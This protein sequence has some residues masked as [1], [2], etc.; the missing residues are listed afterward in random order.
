MDSSLNNAI[1]IEDLKS[2][3]DE[4]LDL[5]SK[6]LNSLESVLGR[7]SLTS[8]KDQKMEGLITRFLRNINMKV[9]DLLGLRHTELVCEK[10]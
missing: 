5:F 6:V 7:L 2:Y 4:N 8:Q 9:M 1:K 3:V 10:L